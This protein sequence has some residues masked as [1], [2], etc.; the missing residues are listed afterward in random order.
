MI[1]E[2]SD[3]SNMGSRKNDAEHV[4]FLE[5]NGGYIPSEGKISLFYLDSNY[6]DL[7]CYL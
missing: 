3:C 2:K 5:A 4:K 7:D 6:T 1:A